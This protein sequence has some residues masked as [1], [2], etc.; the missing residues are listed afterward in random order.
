MMM[1]TRLLCLDTARGATILVGGSSTSARMNNFDSTARAQAS[2][3]AIA[4]MLFI[5]PSATSAAN[6]NNRFHRPASFISLGM[7]A[8]RHR[9]CWA[10]ELSPWFS[11]STTSTG[12]SHRFF[13]SR[14][15]PRVAQHVPTVMS[16]GNFNE[17]EVVEHL[18]HD[19]RGDLALLASKFG[20]MIESVED[21]EE[22][23]ISEI[24]G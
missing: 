2:L 19:F 9:S 20:T 18:E 4:C 1:L 3:L 16:A 10:R 17:A 5:A 15:P 24:D 21:I 12:A 13:L 7:T 11:R 8:T 14:S 22:V 23:H 6:H